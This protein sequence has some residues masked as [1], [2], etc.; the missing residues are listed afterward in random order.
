MRFCI[1]FSSQV[2]GEVI[3]ETTETYTIKTTAGDVLTVHKSDV[4]VLT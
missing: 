1:L 3:N 4:W 2:Y